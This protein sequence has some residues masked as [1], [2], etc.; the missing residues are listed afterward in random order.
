MMLHEGLG[1]A[2]LWRDLPARLCSATGLDVVAYSR[3]GNGFSEIL[4]TDRDVRYMHDEALIVLPELLR[5]CNL[6]DVVLLGHSD[7]ASIALIYAG[8]GV[9]VRAVV[10]EAPHVFVEELSVRSI[11]LARERYETA[12][13]RERLSR[14]HADVDRTFYGWNRVWLDPAFR[15]W[16]VESYAAKVTAPLLLIQGENDEYGTREQ[17]N[18]IRRAA[19]GSRVDEIYVA[20]SGHSPHRERADIVVPALIAFIES[21]TA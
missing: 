9:T 6:H 15:S 12:G 2:A 1:S 4:E 17:L 7:G 8:S 16:N 3:F 10:A 21:V 19:A 14:Y 13:L 11:A 20:D 5:A 18:A